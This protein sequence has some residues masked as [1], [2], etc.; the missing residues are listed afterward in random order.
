MNTAAEQ[1]TLAQVR[2]SL[3]SPSPEVEV[4]LPGVSSPR[5]EPMPAA[6]AKGRRSSVSS[7]PSQAPRVGEICSP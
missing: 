5:F 3:S 1:S 4:V 6:R 7:A 2:S